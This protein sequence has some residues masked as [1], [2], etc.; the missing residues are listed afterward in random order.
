MSDKVTSLQPSQ[1]PPVGQFRHLIRTPNEPMTDHYIP[2]PD[3][4]LAVKSFLWLHRSPS[5]R[6]NTPRTMLIQGVPNS[7]KT[8][9][10]MHAALTMGTAVAVIPPSTFSSKHEGGGVDALTELLHDLER[11]SHA[12]KQH[13]TAL[14]DDIDHSILSIGETGT[15]GH[16]VNTADMVGHLQALSQSRMTHTCFDGTAI[17]FLATSNDASKMAPSLMRLGRAVTFTHEVNDKA[18]LE[19]ARHHFQPQSATEKA[20]IDKLVKTYIKEQIGFWPALASLYDA[21]RLASA[22]AA[23]GF[24][25]ERMEQVLNGYAPLNM[26]LLSEL[27]EHCRK[28]RPA[29]FLWTR[30]KL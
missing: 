22:V 6:L 19:L 5:R 7:G 16:T 9:I 4:E 13:V 11:H 30:K 21:K 29:N 14:F 18:K 26:T 20:F 15:T 3:L 10:S 24:N 17:P 2:S 12:T 28:D 25:V 27:A 23:K 8:F 1:L